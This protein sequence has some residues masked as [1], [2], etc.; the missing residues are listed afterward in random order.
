MVIYHFQKDKIIHTSAYENLFRSISR[1]EPTSQV[2]KSEPE[3]KLNLD[4]I[5]EKIFKYGLNSLKKE[6]KEFLDNASNQN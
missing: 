5:L 6:E 1:Y 4:D 2:N 3:I